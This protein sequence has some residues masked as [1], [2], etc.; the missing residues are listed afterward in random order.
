MM[1]KLNWKKARSTLEKNKI[2][3]EL[4]VA[5]LLSFMAIFVSIQAN[6]ISK[7]Q[8]EIMQFENS[9]QIEIRMQQFFNDSLNYYDKKE[10]FVYNRNSKLA[11]FNLEESFSFIV[12]YKDY[13]FTKDSIVFS[14]PYYLNSAGH[15]SGDNEGLLYKFDSDDNGQ[16]IRNLDLA[17]RDLGYLQI[18]SYV[19][20]TYS[21]IFKNRE[22]VYFQISPKIKQISSKEWKIVETLYMT[23]FKTR[24]PLAEIDSLEFRSILNNY[25]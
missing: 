6:N 11:D 9:P 16:F 8:T 10:W 20:A 15:L 18:N 2:L 14:L 4:I 23:K 19:K 13:V 3:F 22:E 24:I 7:R 17:S 25:R 21:T 5:T 1:N 12:F